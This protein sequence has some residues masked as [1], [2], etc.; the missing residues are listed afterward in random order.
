MVNAG[1]N[2]ARNGVTDCPESRNEEKFQSMELL[3]SSR[4]ATKILRI[5]RSTRWNKVSEILRISSRYAKPYLA[6]RRAARVH[7]SHQGTCLQVLIVVLPVETH[8]SRNCFS[9][10]INNIDYLMTSKAMSL[11]L[12]VQKDL[13]NTRL[14]SRRKCKTLDRGRGGNVVLPATVGQNLSTAVKGA[15]FVYDV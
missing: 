14:M 1:E 8:Q 2:R 5:L 9:I 15:A 12:N 6:P 7:G 10:I 3:D 13:I 11:T 4:Y